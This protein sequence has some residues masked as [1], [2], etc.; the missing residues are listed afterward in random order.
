MP[1]IKLATWNVNSIRIRLD[2]LKLFCSLVSPD[3]VCIQEVKAKAEDFPF[4]EIKK[5]GFEHIALYGQAGYNGVA[6]LS[7]IPLQNIEQQDWVGKHDARHIKATILD[8]I[9]INNIYIPAG[10]DVPDPIE[11]ISFAHKLCFIDD[12]SEYFEQHKAKW[13]DK[14]MIVCGD[15]NVAP[16]EHDVWGHKQLLKTVSHTP[17]EV[18]RINRLYNSLDFVDAI[19][20]IY[21][22]PQK[23]YSWWSYRNPNW[24]SNDK[25]RRLDHIW[26]TPN[27]QN[28]IVDAYV[29]K[30]MRL[31]NRPSD[32][33]P[34]VVELSY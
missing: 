34:V 26:V 18:E 30:E 24:Q 22:E 25:G 2:Q 29:I 33:V 23:I 32:H 3:V 15:F 5:I 4:E 12:I 16:L 10:G 11:N 21:P 27:L 19:R 6:I 13:Q 14:K 31:S 17:I 1:K 8:N 9:E 28:Q 20:K 7:K